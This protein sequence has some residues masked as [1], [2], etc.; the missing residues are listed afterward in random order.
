MRVVSK[1][2]QGSILGPHFE[3]PPYD[4]PLRLVM[5]EVMHQVQYANAVTVLVAAHSIKRAQCALEMVVLRVSG[6]MND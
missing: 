2:I 3:D 5:P 4:D 6:W 1:T